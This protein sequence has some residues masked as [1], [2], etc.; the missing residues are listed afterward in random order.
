[1]ATPSSSRIPKRIPKLVEDITPGIDM[2]LMAGASD[3][4][5]KW[6]PLVCAGVALGIGVLA[7]NEIR[8]MKDDFVNKKTDNSEIT[9]KME[10]MDTQMKKMNEYLAKKD[11]NPVIK[12]VLKTD[13]PA[14]VNVVNYES[15]E[16]YEE[17]E[18]TDDEADN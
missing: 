2:D 10:N 1:M 12:A 6:A 16:E 5:L 13:V 17:V 3:S 15:Q 14:P 18:V 9:K 8:S 7:L 4:L 11:S